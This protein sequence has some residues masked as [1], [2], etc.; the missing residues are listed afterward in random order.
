MKVQKKNRGYRVFPLALS[1][2]LM[3]G[4]LLCGFTPAKQSG[5][6][7]PVKNEIS[8]NSDEILRRPDQKWFQASMFWENGYIIA[9]AWNVDSSQYQTVRQIGGKTVSFTKK[10]KQYADDASITK[11]LRLVIEEQEKGDDSQGKRLMEEPVFLGVDGPFDGPSDE[12]SQ[13]FYKDDNIVYFS[14]V[15]KKAETKTIEELAGKAALDGKTDFFAVASELLPVSALS[16]YAET[17]YREDRVDIFAI[18]ADRLPKKEAAKLAKQ[19]V[20]DGK[21]YFFSVV[22]D[23]LSDQ[24]LSEVSLQAYENDHID[25][26]YMVCDK[27]GAQQADLIAG[28]AYAD[29][30]VDFIYGIADKMTDTQREKLSQQAKKEGKLDFWYI[31]MK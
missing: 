19:A 29:D 20:K 4:V 14:A 9:L 2:L 24:E 12:L 27:I 22:M 26:F 18:A 13:Q 8:W 1:M 10:T 7:V 30:R 21:A 15:I 6:T 16:K 5:R 3:T 11:T 25:I 17:A 28:K 31:L 23:S